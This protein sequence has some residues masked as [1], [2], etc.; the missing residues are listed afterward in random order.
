MIIVLAI[1]PKVYR[2]KP[3]QEQWIFKGD[4]NSIALLSFRWEAKQSAPC[5]KIL[6]HVK[7]PLR[8]DSDTVRQNSAAISCL[9]S[10]CFAIRCL[11]QSVHS[12]LVNESGMIKTQMWSTVDL[13][14]AAVHGMLYDTTS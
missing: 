10:L 12:T 8:Y 2:L 14:M 3:G 5:H 13:K 1:G 9:V 11:L 4:K 7:D 6:Q